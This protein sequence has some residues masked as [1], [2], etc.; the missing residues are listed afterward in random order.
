MAVSAYIFIQTEVAKAS[1]VVDACRKLTGVGPGRRCDGSVRRHP[2][3]GGGVDRRA[4]PH[5]RVAGAARRR[6]HPDTH[7]PRRPSVAPTVY[8]VDGSPGL[9]LPAY[10]CYARDPADREPQACSSGSSAGRR[11]SS[12]TRVDWCDGSEA[13]YERALP[14]A[15]RARHVRRRSTRPSG[16]NSFYARS[17][18]GDVARVEDRT[19]IC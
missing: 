3:G 13:E 2:E 14:S 6:D 19:F 9:P 8:T 4:R 7:L 17:D 10:G 11:F 12:P 18:P 5:G 15:R 1:A 16:P